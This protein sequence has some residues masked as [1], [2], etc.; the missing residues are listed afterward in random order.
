MA[1]SVIIA[2]LAVLTGVAIVQYVRVMQPDK[3][4]WYHHYENC[5]KLE[6]PLP[7]KDLTEFGSLILAA[8]DDQSNLFTLGADYVQN[9]KLFALYDLNTTT[10]FYREVVISEYPPELYFHP[11]G[12]YLVRTTNALYVLNH[13][14][15]R[16]G[17][18]V[19][20]FNL[21][22]APDTVTARYHGAMLLPEEL[23]GR[24]G[25]LIVESDFEVYLSEFSSRPLAQTG[26]PQPW[27]SYY[28][29]LL[30]NFLQNKYAHVWQCTFELNS[31]GNCRSL[32]NTAAV[33]VTGITKDKFGMY[34]VSYS[35]FDYNWVEY[36]E[37][38]WRKGDFELQKSIALR[39]RIERIEWDHGSQR[40]YGGSMPWFFTH[41]GSIPGGVVEIKNWEAGSGLVYR[42]L[43]IQEHLQKG[44]NCAARKFDKTIAGSSLDRGV[45][46]CPITGPNN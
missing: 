5:E 11:F 17:T 26:E 20:I 43:Y 35:S 30:D 10:P 3:D 14:F 22:Q 40:V 2:A 12:M 33:S 13:A 36:Y 4:V 42:R 34:M 16:G 27:M 28:Y 39:D 18:R 15:N 8:G 45:L 9:G 37:R 38:H 24:H 19:D 46:I 21:T 6:L 25:D 1:K 23:H 41:S 44:T 7:V 31:V 29:S 32:N